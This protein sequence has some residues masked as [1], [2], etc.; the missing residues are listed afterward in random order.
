MDSQTKK[1]L[2]RLERGPLTAME[3]LRELGVMRLAARIKD[4]KDSG[5]NVVAETVVVPTRDG[6]ARVARYHLTPGAA[7]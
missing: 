7:R 1:V 2:R 5:H 6:D 3:A 4:L